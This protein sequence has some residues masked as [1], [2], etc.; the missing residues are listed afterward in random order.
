MYKW[1]FSRI[2][3]IYYVTITP[4]YR[5]HYALVHAQFV[6]LVTDE[7]FEAKEMGTLMR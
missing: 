6:D 7:Q 2:L 3:L 4:S 5:M 1:V